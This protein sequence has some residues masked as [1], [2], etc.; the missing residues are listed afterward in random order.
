LIPDWDGR[1]YLWGI[2]RANKKRGVMESSDNGE[3]IDMDID[4]VGGAELPTTHC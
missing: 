3:V 2:F 1:R 4:M